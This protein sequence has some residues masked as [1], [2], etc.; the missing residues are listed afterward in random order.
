MI[1]KLLTAL[2]ILFIFLTN[3]SF[4]ESNNAIDLNNLSDKPFKLKLNPPKTLD[5]TNTVQVA[6][7]TSYLSNSKYRIS[8]IN[9]NKDN[10]PSGSHYPGYRGANQL[11][12][13]TKDFGQSTLTNEYGIE[14]IVENNTAVKTSSS[15][16]FIPQNGFVISAH[17]KAKK[18]I[19]QNIIE[20][21]IVNINK[22]TKTLEVSIIPESYLFKAQQLVNIAKTSYDKY[23]R[24][25]KSE[26][27]T[28]AKERLITAQKNLKR[29]KSNLR[30]KHYKKARQLS[31]IASSYAN[32]AIYYSIPAKPDEFHGVWIRPVEKTSQDIILTLEKLK[33]MGIENIF[34]ETYYQGTTIFPSTTMAHYNLTT[35]RKE[36]MGWDPLKV[37]IEEAHKRNMKVHTWFQTFYVGNQNPSKNPKHIL[38]LYPNWANVQRKNIGSVQPMPSLAEHSGY[39][40]DPA[41][42]QV[43]RFLCTLIQEITNNY[44]IDGLNVDYIRYPSSL[45]MNFPNFL[46]STWG[47][48]RYARKEFE[49]MYGI[50]PMNIDHSHL[51]WTYW[52]LYRQNKINNFVF[53]LKLITNNKNIMIS[54]VIFPNLIKSSHIKM[55]NWKTWGDYGFVDA[56]TPLIMNNNE[57]IAYKYVKE[58]KQQFNRPVNIYPG[59]FEP[60]TSSSPIDMLKQIEAIRE[61]GGQGIVLFDNAH[62]KNEYIES[63]KARIFTNN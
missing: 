16:S 55:Q 52:M 15:D 17:G 60:F 43:Q 11:I 56:F 33:D 9:P 53:N 38:S 28:I 54:T 1:N 23:Y 42:P 34:L 22:N 41:N 25:N 35:Q 49:N 6:K 2:L 21:A 39:F 8:A 32:Q 29:A 44:N 30:K 12:I 4:A 20:G 57:K 61:A 58:I 45:A 27:S 18:W 19:N 59:L 47:Y 37:W 36:F 13:Y 50:D 5:N 14:V 7:K 24:S 62:L 48:T 63:L 31:S 40:L 26:K 3:Q 46:N 10:N 51:L